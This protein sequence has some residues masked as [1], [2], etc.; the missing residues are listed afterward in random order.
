MSWDKAKISDIC[1][2]IF[3]GP[4]ATPPVSKDGAIF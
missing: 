4:H 1:S 2:D 3:D